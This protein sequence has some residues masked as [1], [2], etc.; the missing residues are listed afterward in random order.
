MQMLMQLVKLPSYRDYWLN[1]LWY[2]PVADNMPKNRYKLLLQNLHFVDN[3]TYTEESG[4]L[5]KI[6]P[7]IEAI[8]RQCIIIEPKCFHATDEQVIPSR[9][10]FIK[11]RQYNPKKLCKWSFKNMVRAG[12]SWFMY[13]FYLY[14][15]KKHTNNIN[16]KC[17]FINQFSVSGTFKSRITKTYTKDP[18]L[19]KLVFKAWAGSLPIGCWVACC[20]YH[21]TESIAWLLAW[22]K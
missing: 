19:W 7:V 15:E 9:T 11:I 1:T 8:R 6:V 4:K 3:T 20:R 5:F 2:P 12:S 16:R 21:Q 22:L 18:F 14:V 10:K 13:G 17:P